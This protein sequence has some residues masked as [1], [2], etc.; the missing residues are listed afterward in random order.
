[1]ALEANRE[2]DHHIDQELRRY[3]VA[4]GS[5]IHKGALVARDQNGYAIALTAAS[6][7]FIGLAYEQIDNT[8]GDNGDQ[9]VRVYTI[10]DFTLPLA[11]T[12]QT[13]IGRPVFATED[14]TLS[15]AG[16]DGPYV[17]LIIDRLAGEQVVLRIDPTRAQIKTVTHAV[18]DLSAGTDIQ[19]RAIHAFEHAAWIVQAQL[20]NQATAATGVNSANTCAVSLDTG[21]G[22]IAGAVF[23]TTNPFPATN[24][25]KSL[26]TISNAHTPA[27]EVLTLTVTN[28]AT[29]NPGPF[30]VEVA[31]V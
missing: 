25:A 13:D 24:R 2:V 10:G 26:G 29:A 17:G 22:N 31:Y 12:T 28:G 4:A 27:G 15:L 23:N 8:A 21:A 14:D 3:P 16:E 5:L 1:M 7:N 30:L 9:H 6:A 20:V 11:G 19:A 18:E